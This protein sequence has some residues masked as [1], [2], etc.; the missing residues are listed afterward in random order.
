MSTEL[1]VMAMIHYVS[2]SRDRLPSSRQT[3]DSGVL[4]CSK[5]PSGSRLHKSGQVGILGGRPFHANGPD[6]GVVGRSL[7][8]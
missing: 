6:V 1:F 3:Q 5:V 7:A 2:M 8:S 4:Q